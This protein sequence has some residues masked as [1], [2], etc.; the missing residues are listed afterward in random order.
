[1]VL[2][3]GCIDLWTAA[4]EPARDSGIFAACA[5][6]L[7]PEE[8]RDADRFV[9]A[10]DR[11]RAV[12]SRAHL[13]TVLS[14]YAPLAPRDWRFEPGPHG[15]PEIAGARAPDLRFSVAHTREH[16]VCAVTVLDAIGVDLEPV[17]R[18][19]SDLLGAT[20]IL[21]AREIEALQATAP[22]ERSRRFL[23]IWTRKEAYL[24]A[25]GTGLSQAPNEVEIDRV[26]GW[27]F[28][29]P[30]VVPGHV[31]ALAQRNRGR[32]VELRTFARGPWIG[33]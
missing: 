14:R 28:A 19:V 9:H 13:R 22:P 21:A 20:S 8:R 32:P 17:G 4:T 15:R 5:D 6:V 33:N 25:L 16:V 31:V 24:K 7:P 12:V 3:T 11:R 10:A 1:M 23:E 26:A 29:L 30:E 27:W 2:Q 18:D